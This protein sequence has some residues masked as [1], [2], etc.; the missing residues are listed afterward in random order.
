VI[1]R[2]SRPELAGGPQLDVATGEPV[3]TPS[4]GYIGRP[5]V[6]DQRGSMSA[7]KCPVQLVKDVLKLRK[8]LMDRFG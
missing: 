1:Q 3:E 6:M 7:A 5:V 4:N 8:C 2:A